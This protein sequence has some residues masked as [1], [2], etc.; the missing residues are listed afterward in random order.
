MA[1]FRRSSALA[2]CLLGPLGLTL[3]GASVAQ[4]TARP[5]AVSLAYHM[6]PGWRPASGVPSSSTYVIRDGDKVHL[7]T[8]R[9]VPPKTA[10]DVEAYAASEIDRSKQH[11]AEVVDEGATTV[12]DGTAAH[13][14]TVRDADGGLPMVMHVLAAAVTGGVATMTYAHRQ[15]V[16]DRK[17]GLDA[18]QTLCPGPYPSPVPVGWT[19]PKTA[20][21][22]PIARL[23]SPDGTSSF[24]TAYRLMD[25]DKFPAYERE[26]AP[27]GTVLADH[28]D[29]CAGGTVHRVDVQVGN[30]ISEVALAY[31]HHVAYRYV[32]TR[33]ATHDADAGAER[34]LTSFCRPFSP[35]AS[36]SNAPV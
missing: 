33:P 32:Y 17:D 14:W 8:V 36:P 34:A 24:L 35:V 29:P 3:G 18:M 6:P 10:T 13:R 5:V 1:G 27:S 15:D 7:L 16:G 20:T 4:T 22:T 11:G 31:M 2:L 30:Q 21:A 23:E 19:A 12:C 9:T 25:A 26:G 28:R